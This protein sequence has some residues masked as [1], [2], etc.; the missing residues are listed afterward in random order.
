VLSFEKLIAAEH[1]LRKLKAAI[2]FEPVR[3]LV[4]EC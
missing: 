1:Y 2:D 3:A 4:A